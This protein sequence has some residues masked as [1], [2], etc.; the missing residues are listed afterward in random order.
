[1]IKTL[2]TFTFSME[3]EKRENSLEKNFLSSIFD[4]K[5]IVALNTFKKAAISKR[6][7]PYN[8]HCYI[9]KINSD[10]FGDL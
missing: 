3:N 10:V 5:M 1:M 2:F 4:G 8:D 6:N 9:I 7:E